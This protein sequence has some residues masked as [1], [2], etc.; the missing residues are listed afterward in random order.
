MDRAGLIIP[1]LESFKRIIEKEYI[2]YNY[3]LLTIKRNHYYDLYSY[4]DDNINYCC[5]SCK[6]NN[7]WRSCGC[8]C[9]CLYKK[10]NK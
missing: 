5:I 3:G 8:G 1:P 9:V 4:P 7:S 2:D 6:H 10:I